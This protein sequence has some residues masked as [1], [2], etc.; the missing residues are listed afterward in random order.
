MKCPKVLDKLCLILEN[1]KGVR[2]HMEQKEKQSLIV[3]SLL[4]LLNVM[5]APIYNTRGGLFPSNVKYNFI[6]V[7]GLIFED[8]DNLEMEVVKFTLIILV[9]SIFMLVAALLGKDKL[10]SI[11]NIVGS[12]FLW[13]RI[14]VLFFHY[15][16]IE[17]GLPYIFSFERGKISIGVWIAVVLFGVASH[18]S[19][20]YKRQRLGSANNVYKK[21]S[22]GT[23]ENGQDFDLGT[24]ELSSSGSKTYFTNEKDRR[25][26]M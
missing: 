21:Q 16:S 4:S 6:E 19:G 2:A 17:D 26:M 12:C 13:T 11:A 15:A 5:F 1:K 25:N 3:I 14:F 18:V 23:T 22:Y 10:F 7:I 8:S 9:P 24:N 20:K